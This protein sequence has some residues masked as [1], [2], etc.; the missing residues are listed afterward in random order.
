[1]NEELMERERSMIIEHRGCLIVGRGE[2]GWMVAEHVDT[3]AGDERLF[4]Y[5]HA[6]F[7]SLVRARHYIDRGCADDRPR[8]TLPP[9][10]AAHHCRG[11]GFVEGGARPQV[12]A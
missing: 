12:S 10:A 2:L 9:A 11:A 4:A 8:P 3:T 6:P 5:C 1:M 7:P